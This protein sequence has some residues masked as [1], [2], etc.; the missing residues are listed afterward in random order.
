MY[1]YSA[2]GT[3]YAIKFE[4]QAG[5]QR[6]CSGTGDTY[7]IDIDIHGNIAIANFMRIKEVFCF[8]AQV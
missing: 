4:V 2:Y 5:T 1:R 6:D 7:S 3:Q 8:T